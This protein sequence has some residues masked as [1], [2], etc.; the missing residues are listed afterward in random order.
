MQTL[1][2]TIISI[3]LGV[4]FLTI[5]ISGVLL[6]RKGRD[7]AGAAPVHPVLYKTGKICSFLLWITLFIVPI[8]PELYQ[9]IPGI[10]FNTFA[11]M[12][13]TAAAIS[14]AASL[15]LIISFHTLGDSLKFGLP[16]GERGVFRKSGLYRFSRN[17]MYFAFAL[18]S[19]AIVLY[20]PGFL[21]LFSAVFSF[22]V[23]HQIILA[24][25]AY[26]RI[27]WGDQYGDYMRK[28]RRYI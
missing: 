10:F 1:P 23:H 21:I 3:A 28:V 9:F 18:I 25:E 8:H 7:F 2:D 19:T 14:V 15:I 22:Y 6:K 27:T 5:L 4:I 24:E 17:P 20:L 26:M 12:K 11:W 13:W 16:R